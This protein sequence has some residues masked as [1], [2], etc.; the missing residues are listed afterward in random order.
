VIGI[1]RRQPELAEDIADVL[2]SLMMMALRPA[3]V[4]M[5]RCCRGMAAGSIVA[6]PVMRYG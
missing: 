1:G 4:F 6:S 3:A 5:L 2:L